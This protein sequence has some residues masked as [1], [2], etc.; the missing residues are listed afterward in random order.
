MIR[1]KKLYSLAKKCNSRNSTTDSH[2]A[3]CTCVAPCCTPFTLYENSEKDHWIHPS[4]HRHLHYAQRL[5]QLPMKRTF[6]QE[7][8]ADA[9][10]VNVTKDSF[11][12]L[13]GRP[14]SYS[15]NDCRASHY[16]NEPTVTTVDN[17]NIGGYK[18][19]YFY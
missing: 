9:S 5:K 16:R 1:R 7:K 3:T 4:S 18:P 12:N 6:Y 14:E 19:F 11:T 17:L 10:A 8:F 15:D 2:C 13:V